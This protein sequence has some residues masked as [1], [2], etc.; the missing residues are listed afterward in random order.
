MFRKL[1][2]TLIKNFEGSQYSFTTLQ[3]KPSSL[4][5]LNSYS[6]DLPLT[7]KSSSVLDQFSAYKRIGPSALT[8]YSQYISAGLNHLD[9]AEPHSAHQL[10]QKAFKM[11]GKLFGENSKNAAMCLNYI[12]QAYQ[13]DENIDKS[14][15]FYN[16]AL[17]MITSQDSFVCPTLSSDI[18]YKMSIVYQSQ[19]EMSKAL[20]N[21]QKSLN[22]LFEYSPEDNQR[23]SLV[24]QSLGKTH[25]L[26][27]DLSEAKAYLEK[28]LEVLLRDETKN[29]VEL[30]LLYEKIG[31][32]MEREGKIHEA[33]KLK[34]KAL[35]I[36]SRMQIKGEEY[37]LFMQ[38]LNLA[39]LYEKIEKFPESFGFLQKAYGLLEKDKKC[40]ESV[41]KGPLMIRKGQMLLKM[42]ELDKAI[43]AVKEGIRLL[44]DENLGGSG[45]V[46]KARKI[47]EKA[48]SLKRKHQKSFEQKDQEE[49]VMESRIVKD[50]GEAERFREMG[51]E[52][53]KEYDVCAAQSYFIKALQGFAFVNGSDCK[54]C[55]E[56]R[57]V[58]EDLKHCM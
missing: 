17:C 51:Y 52:K 23:I 48:M 15:E 30:G 57:K 8:Q 53:M 10:F 4:N 3:R 32:L 19:G 38:Y 46:R 43:E 37:A 7:E 35:E 25:L 49:F 50:V 39:A 44:E 9:K 34:T 41:H 22:I 11:S 14:L 18:F 24:L 55:K 29:A 12:A 26:M 33:I 13:L 56:L 58:L 1:T 28:A 36:N 31:T 45:M 42:G 27:G 54:Q 40:K 21:G 6:K 5:V 20:Q 2:T 47:L 16:K